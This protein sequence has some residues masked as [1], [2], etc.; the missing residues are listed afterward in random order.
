MT[1][2]RP[3]G[4]ASQLATWAGVKLIGNTILTG[5]GP[6]VDVSVIA[7]LAPQRLHA[8]L[9][10][11]RC[12]A[13]E[14]VVRQ[15]HAIPEGTEFRG[16]FIGELLRRFARGLGCT[17]DL[18]TVFVGAGQ[19]PGVIPQHPVPPRDRVAD[20][21][22]V[23]VPN[24]RMRIDVVDR[25]RDVKLLAHSCALELKILPRRLKPRPFK[26]KSKSESGGLKL[27]SI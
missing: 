3:P 23:G 27:H 9:V 7:N 1:W 18:L 17:L 22:G 13:D 20:N 6:L 11:L 24:V 19:E 2:K 8:A 4:H 25:G 14:I 26:T 12:G 16:N 21:R 15:A 10:A 5:V